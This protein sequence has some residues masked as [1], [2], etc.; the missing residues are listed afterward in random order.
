MSSERNT[1]NRFDF[2]G[3]CKPALEELARTPALYSM[4]FVIE[5]PLGAVQITIAKTGLGTD[6]AEYP[7]AV[8]LFDSV[9]EDAATEIGDPC[10]TPAHA[11]QGALVALRKRAA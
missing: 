3:R 8:G 4:M 7:H 5:T 10:P 9:G 2:T 11:L 6:A 1:G